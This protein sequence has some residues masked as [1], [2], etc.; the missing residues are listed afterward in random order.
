MGFLNLELYC[1]VVITKSIGAH[2]AEMEKT[3]KNFVLEILEN[4]YKT[5]IA[6]KVFSSSF[7]IQYLDKKTRSVDRSSKSRASFA[8]IYAIYVLVKDYLKI[9]ASKSD[10]SKYEGIRF[11]EALKQ[12][13]SLPWGNKL[14]NHAL[15]HRLNEEFK[16]FFGAETKQL[17]IIRDLTTR[18]Y[19]F[20][21]KL[22]HVKLNGEEKNIA[23]VVIEIIDQYIAL[24]QEGYEKFI[25]T[26]KKL[27]KSFDAKKVFDFINLT[28]SENTDARLFEIVSYCV[29]KEHY[30]HDKSVLYRTGRTNANDGGIDFVLKPGGRFFQV[31]EVLD[32]EKYFLDIEKLNH[33]PITFVI[34]TEL[35]P[36]ESMEYIIV[37]A[38]KIYNKE[39]VRGY[40]NCF[41][42]IITLPVLRIYLQEINSLKTT[43]ELL[44]EL[45]IQY[46]TEYNLKD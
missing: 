17:P 24:K 44:D 21:E 45:M 22:L 39:K 23:E 10:Y 25:N 35:S 30:K 26:C 34:K 28:L 33:Y 42:E 12:V 8:N 38:K 3:H 16:K 29:L 37:D 43:R 46:Q 2:V 18:Y 32:F 15:N 19:W 14:Q 36:K 6:E 9:I 11:S 5:E 4:H 7:L 41:E 27:Q 40:L 1:I 31:T 13:R 20:N